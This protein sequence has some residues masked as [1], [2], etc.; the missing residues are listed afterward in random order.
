MK[1]SEMKRNFD[2]LDENMDVKG[3]VTTSV[4]EASKGPFS[5]I[6]SA[7]VGSGDAVIQDV[8]PS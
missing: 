3:Q 5:W 1:R 4:V 2:D 7:R 6:G 8:A